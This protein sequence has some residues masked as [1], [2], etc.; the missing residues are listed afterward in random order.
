MRTLILVSLGALVLWG[1]GGCATKEETA[2]KIYVQQR[3]YDKAISQGRQALAK[4]PDNGDTHY[5]M[6]VAYYGKDSELK[7]EEEGYAD[8]SEAFLRLSYD[9]FMKAKE[10]AAAIKK[11]GGKAPYLM[12]PIGP[13]VAINAG[14]KMLGLGFRKKAE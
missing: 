9:H 3:L 7:P 14:P 1:L 6:G 8:S 11:L 2:I 10:L 13:C 5:F 4:S 12:G